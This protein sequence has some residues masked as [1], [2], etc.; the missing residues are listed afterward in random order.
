MKCFENTHLD[1]ELGTP[2]F[3]NIGAN[4]EKFDDEK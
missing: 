4:L 2:G 1:G 3:T